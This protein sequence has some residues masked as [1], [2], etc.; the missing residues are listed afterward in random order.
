MKIHRTLIA[1]VAIVAMIPVLAHADARLVSVTPT[2]GGCVWGPSGNYVQAWDVEPGETYTLRLE[3]V[4]ECAAGGTDPLL[5]VRINSSN[6]G[7][8]DLVAAWVAPGVYEF[9]FTVPLDG[10]CTM[11]V[12][13]CTTPGIYSTGIHAIRDDG[14]AWQAHLRVSTFEAGCTNPVEILGGDCAP[15]DLEEKSWG[16]LKAL[17][18]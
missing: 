5:D 13:Y 3:D 7:N 17:F 10:M 11:P 1:L 6:T 4:L 12:F 15:I 18:E 2:G 9:D 16:V 8:V 14:A